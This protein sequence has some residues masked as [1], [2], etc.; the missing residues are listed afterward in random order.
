MSGETSKRQQFVGLDMLR[1]L[2]AS[3]VMF[4]HFGFWHWVNGVG[5]LPAALGPQPRGWD[6][7]N[8]GWVGVE[9]FFV[10]SGFVIAFSSANADAAKFLKSRVLRLAPGAWICATLDLLIFRMVLHKTW[11]SLSINY[12]C[13]LL[14]WPFRAIDGVYWTLGVEI[15]FYAL[16]YGLILLN[17]RELLPRIMMWV[18]AVSGLFWLAA[19]SLTAGLAHSTGQLATLHFLV[20]KAEGNRI[21]QL[22]LVQHGSY[23]A[24]GILLYR[25]TIERLTPGRLA[26]MAG[27]VCVALMEIYA[28]NALISRL[29]GVTLSPIPAEMAWIVAMAVLCMSI[30]F[31]NHIHNYLSSIVRLSRYLGNLTY[32]LYLVHDGIGL[33]VTAILA[34]FIGI[35]AIFVGVISAMVGAGLLEHFAET[36]LRR[37]MSRWIGAKVSSPA[38]VAQAGS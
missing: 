38:R 37:V 28:Q 19:L 6:V 10:I 25:T 14:F 3:L 26:A 20:Q 5:A 27:L 2:A 9:I 1:I 11:S 35:Y 33:G 13:T 32:I 22:L 18:G 29:S 8:F 12:L 34:P 30:Y 7:M 4:Y 21:L 23:F 17:K 36:P 16:V 15:S 31:N 24:L